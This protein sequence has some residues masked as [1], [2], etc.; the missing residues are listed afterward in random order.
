MNDHVESFIHS[1]RFEDLPDAVIEQAQYCLL[2]LLGVAAAGSSTQLAQI[3]C[4]HA[5]EFFGAGSM[6]TRLLF[7]GRIAS[8]L[9]A[10]LAGAM[11]I[12]SFDGHD[13]HSL[14]KGH[15]GVA[16]LPAL[17]AMAELDPS[18]DGRSFLTSL[19]LGY[20]IGTRAGIALHATSSEYHTS[21]AWNALAAA[22]IIARG[23]KLDIERTRHALGI[24][25]YHGPRSDMMR[26]IDFPTMVKDGSGW[27]CV[28][29]VSA[30]LLAERH[31]TGAP[32][33]TVEAHDQGALWSDLGQR[34]FILE[35]YFKPFP[36]CRWAHPAIACALH[37]RETDVFVA[38]A[39]ESVE[40]ETFHEATRLC[41]SVP[42]TTEEAQY[43][44]LFPVAAALLDGRVDAET[45]GP[46]GLADARLRYLIPRMSLRDSA[47]FSAL[48]PAQRWARVI[49]HTRDGKRLDSG[50]MQSQGDPERPLPRDALRAK[51]RAFTE[52][53]I[54]LERAARIEREVFVLTESAHALTPLLDLVLTAPETSPA[55]AI[56]SVL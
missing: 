20:E 56:R 50:A 18:M 3:A 27:G 37:L 42:V 25:E 29:G 7:N 15:V 53:R 6:R 10:A 39:I 40:I 16:V 4:D 55:E 12:D 26:C 21:G 28:A 41:S 33:L 14:T 49:V 36:V 32:A 54:G 47:S 8:P 9:G 19:V 46:N 44:V 2:D 13:G 48:F 35:Q 24:A 34:W 5:A 51:F 52:P 23:L 1:L 45:I 30:A 22:A 17:L 31:F 38:D 43:G 11:T